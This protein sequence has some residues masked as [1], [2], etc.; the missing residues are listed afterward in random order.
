MIT[1]KI[2]DYTDVLHHVCNIRSYSTGIRRIDAIVPDEKH[3]L[4][5]PSTLCS[6]KSYR[7][8]NNKEDDLKGRSSN[9]WHNQAFS[10]LVLKAMLNK[11]AIAVDVSFAEFDQAEQK[12]VKTI[13][14]DHG[15]I[16]LVKTSHHG[17]NYSNS[18]YLIDT[19]KP[20]VMVVTSRR[21]SI[22]KSAP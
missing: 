13:Y 19:F 6:Y 8:I 7:H 12:I 21:T 9:S 22:N 3:S 18:K 20:K 17:Y 1:K 15:N 14:D 16:E 2:F 10:Y 5:D 11:G 4:I